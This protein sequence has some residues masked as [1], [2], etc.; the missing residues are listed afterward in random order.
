MLSVLVQKVTIDVQMN[1]Q[2]LKEHQMMYGDQK[3]EASN[4]IEMID[5]D[6]HHNNKHHHH[7]QNEIPKWVA[8]G[9]LWNRNAG[10]RN[11]E[12]SF[13]RLLSIYFF[14]E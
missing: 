8:I 1:H 11:I 10:I 12:N 6:H 5:E 7:H 4:R 14:F 2:Q 13:D 3:Q 9:E